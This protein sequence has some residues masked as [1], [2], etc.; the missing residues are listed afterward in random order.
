MKNRQSPF[1]LSASPSLP[2]S[3]SLHLPCPPPLP[4]VYIAPLLVVNSFLVLITLLQHTHVAVPRYVES[5]WEWLK[6]A[7]CTVDRDYGVLNHGEDSL[8]ND[9][10]PW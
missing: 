7:L 10:E 8:R 4:Q 1:F 3:P 6:G 2:L 9:N 5:E